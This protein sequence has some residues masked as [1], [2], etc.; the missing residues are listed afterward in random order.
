MHKRKS[1]PKKSSIK[2]RKTFVTGFHDFLAERF[3]TSLGV[4]CLLS[5]LHNWINLGVYKKKPYWHGQYRCWEKTCQAR[6]EAQLDFLDEKHED[7]KILISEIKKFSHNFRITKIFRVVAEN[8]E[9]LATKIC[10][11]GV[12]NVLSEN[13][14]SDE[15]I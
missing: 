3:Q 4:L 6:F 11:D 14:I 15:C 12:A 8:R 9:N 2:N 5:N 1:R 7:V 10:A 13:T